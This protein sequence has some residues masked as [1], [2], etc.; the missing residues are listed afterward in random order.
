MKKNPRTPNA[1]GAVGWSAWLGLFLSLISWA[2]C[3]LAAYL[4]LNGRV[5]WSD[6]KIYLGSLVIC[7]CSIAGRELRNK[8]VRYRF[9]IN[10]RRKDEGNPD[11]VNILRSEISHELR[12]TEPDF[13]SS[14]GA[15]TKIKRQHWMMSLDAHRPRPYG[16]GREVSARALG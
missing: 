16:C 11:R 8:P 9:N 2:M 7:L 1:G 5:H 15:V 4:T 3:A 14:R 10:M 13:D 6:A 12:W